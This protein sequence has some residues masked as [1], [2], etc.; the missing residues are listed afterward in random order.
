VLFIIDQYTG[1]MQAFFPGQG[2]F[3][4][5]TAE[6]HGKRLKAYRQAAGLSQRELARQIGERQ[7]N[8][9]YWEA[10]GKLPRSN[11]LVP[12]AKALGISVPELLGESKPKRSGSPGGRLGRVIDELTQLPRRQQK[13]IVDVVEALVVQ[14]KADA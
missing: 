13:Q 1:R 14:K 5:M 10:S 4:S 2:Y 3:V 11:V 12:M 8:V 6:S 7:S 9:Q